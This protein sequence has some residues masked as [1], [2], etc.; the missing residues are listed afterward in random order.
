MDPESLIRFLVGRNSD[1]E[2]VADELLAE[3]ESSDIELFDF[4][5]A[6]GL[7]EREEIL[8][9]VAAAQGREYLDFDKAEI[10]SALLRSI[11]PDIRRIF[12]CLPVEV[13]ATSA[14]VCLAD[15]FDDL[16]VR[17]LSQRLGRRVEVVV[18]DPDQI[19]ARLLD[20]HRS[21]SDE[22]GG[23]ASASLGH[24]PGEMR[25]PEPDKDKALSSVTLVALC[26]LAATS[27]A[28]AA[29]YLRED[30]RGEEIAAL[31]AKN[32]SSF[33]SSEASRKAAD[34]ALVEMRRD[35]DNL[36]RLLAGKEANVIRLEDLEKEV[37]KLRGKIDSLTSIL[38][39]V[40]TSSGKKAEEPSAAETAS[41]P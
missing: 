31:V 27:S 2:R 37:G 36:E 1:G 25:S 4:L 29:I 3:F 14:K 23:L 10:S 11:D 13:S 9:E 19:R 34:R 26:V 5:A 35:L 33:R 40:E 12:E 18:A 41:T 20:S 39:K 32:D 21:G 22:G 17:E 8:R 38:G 16:A 15:P 30:R 28:M 24:L 7:G 6:S